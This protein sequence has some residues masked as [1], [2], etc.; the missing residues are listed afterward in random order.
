[1]QNLYTQS[2]LSWA[3]SSVHLT[4]HSSIHPSIHSLKNPS[5]HLPTKSSHPSMSIYPPF[6]HPTFIHPSVHPSV[7]SSIRLSSIYLSIHLP[8]NPFVNPSSIHPSIINNQSVYV[9]I[10][11]P[12][13]I[14]HLRESIYSPSSHPFILPFVALN[15]G[16]PRCFSWP[17]NCCRS[18]QK[19]QQKQKRSIKL[20]TLSR[21]AKNC[22]SQYFSSTTFSLSSSSS[23]SLPL[24]RWFD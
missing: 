15:I 13:S 3:D 6:I 5:I 11:H 22:C 16:F 18:K 24:S 21:H 2:Y 8:I 19:Q 23:F 17:I 1:M 10:C 7:H 9:S 20:I 12:L 14:H 4:T